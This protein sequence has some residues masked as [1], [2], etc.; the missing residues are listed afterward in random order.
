MPNLLAD[1]ECVV[2]LDPELPDG[3]L[4]LRVPTQELTRTETPGLPVDPIDSARATTIRDR[5][6]APDSPDPVQP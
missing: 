1:R 4:E 5:Q 3:T 6:L 2:R